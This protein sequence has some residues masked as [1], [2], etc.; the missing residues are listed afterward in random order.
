[1]KMLST[2]CLDICMLNSSLMLVKFGD[3]RSLV[4]NVGPGFYSF[5]KTGMGFYYRKCMNVSGSR[6][7]CQWAGRLRAAPT[8]YFF[9]YIK[10]NYTVLRSHLVNQQFSQCKGGGVQ[11]FQMGGVCVRMGGGGGL[12]NNFFP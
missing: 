1:M 5:S 8:N 6:N 11:L 3:N 12:S 9:T 4:A 10:E 2:L 7:F